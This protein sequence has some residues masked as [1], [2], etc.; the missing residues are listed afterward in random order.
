[1]T[2][3]EKVDRFITAELSGGLAG[4]WLRNRA[5][6]VSAAASALLS[7]AFVALLLS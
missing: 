2:L 4:V 6:I 3:S 1:M 7:G 5:A